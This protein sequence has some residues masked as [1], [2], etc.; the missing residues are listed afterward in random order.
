MIY[1]I[2]NFLDKKHC[3]KIIHYFVNSSIR[4][5]QNVSDFYGRTLFPNDI[6]D[7][8]IKRIFHILE[9]KVSQIAVKI[10]PSESH[11]YVEHWDV[12]F[13]DTGKK[14]GPHADNMYPDKTPNGSPFRDY[15]FIIYLNDNYEGGQTYFTNENKVCIPE[16][17][18]IV[19]FPSGLQYTHG[20]LEVKQG[21][22]Y[23]IAGWLTRIENRLYNPSY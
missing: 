13:W 1:E 15:T 7:S 17:G 10:Y 12:V 16:C 19:I 2:V 4:S 20:V 14:M 23:T 8:E 6:D 18:K 22:R 3:D 5:D 9:Y 21:K 11:L